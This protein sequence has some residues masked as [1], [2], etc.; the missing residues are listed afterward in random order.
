MLEKDKVS[1]RVAR[2]IYQA[3]VAS[4]LLHGTKSWVFLP[5]VLRELEGFHVETTQ[6]LAGMCPC[7]VK[8]DWVR[9]HSTD[10]LEVA[11]L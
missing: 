7:K 4:I 9:P 3:T 5:S 6:R 1:P 2:T 10:V 8:G 11:H